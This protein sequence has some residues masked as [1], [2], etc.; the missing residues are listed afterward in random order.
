MSTKFLFVHIAHICNANFVTFEQYRES[1]AKREKS[2][3][4]RLTS[5]FSDAIMPSKSRKE[6]L[7]MNQNLT[8]TLYRHKIELVTVS[9]IRDF[10]AIAGKCK[11]KVMLRCSDDFCIN[12]KSL[13]G[14]MLAKRM[15][16]ND[17]TLLTEN[18]CYQDFK[19]FIAQ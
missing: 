14:V 2:S 1:L 6:V 4:N 13:L 3:K 15:Q 18:D 11:G 5:H 10:V 19:R 9:D 12:A 8:S 17:L 7:H 16:W